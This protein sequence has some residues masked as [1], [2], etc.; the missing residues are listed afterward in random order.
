MLQNPKVHQCIVE[1]FLPYLYLLVPVWQWTSIREEEVRGLQ[2]VLQEFPGQPWSQKKHHRGKFTGQGRS[3]WK[4]SSKLDTN[5]LREQP[6][7]FQILGRDHHGCLHGWG[8]VW[9]VTDVWGVYTRLKRNIWKK[10]VIVHAF[11]AP[12]SSQK[13]V[14]S[15]WSTFPSPLT[16]PIS[17][18]CLLVPVGMSYP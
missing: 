7:Y 13:L 3:V 6:V 11:S 2:S 18:Y 8:S 15:S 4:V 1:N 10:N 9:P 12:G 5:A 17:I 16:W 14:P